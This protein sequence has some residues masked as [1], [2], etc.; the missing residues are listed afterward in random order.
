MWVQMS[1]DDSFVVVGAL[2]VYGQ[3]LQDSLDRGLLPPGERDC[4]IADILRCDR[5]V[6]RLYDEGRVGIPGLS[7]SDSLLVW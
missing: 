6:S 2:R 1:Q 5:L 3:W 4:A 7:D